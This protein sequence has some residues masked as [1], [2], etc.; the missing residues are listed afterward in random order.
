LEPSNG[1]LRFTV[2]RNFWL[3]LLLHGALAIALIAIFIDGLTAWRL[4]T[5]FIGVLVLLD[6]TA[7]L[8]GWVMRRANLWEGNDGGA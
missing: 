1:R 6:I 2:K 5:M 7:L 3:V 4:W 8:A